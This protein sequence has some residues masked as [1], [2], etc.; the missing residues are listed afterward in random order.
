METP[1]IFIVFD[2]DQTKDRLDMAIEANAAND[3]CQLNQS[4]DKANEFVK[5]WAILHDGS[6]VSIAGA[7]IRV[8]IAPEYIEDLPKLKDIYESAV[9]SPVSIGLGLTLSEADRALKCAK[10]DG[11]DKILFYTEECD[12]QIEDAEAPEKDVVAGIAEKFGKPLVKAEHPWQNQFE[13]VIQEQIQAEA[14]KRQAQEANTEL[15]KTKMAVVSI[16]QQVRANAKELESL[17]EE[18]PHLYQ[19]IMAMTQA[20]IMIARQLKQP[21]GDLIPGGK[22]DN[23]DPATLDQEQLK[24]G[25]QEETEEHTNNPQIGQE[26]ATDHLTEDPEFYKKSEEVDTAMQKGEDLDKGINGDWSKEPG[27][28]FQINS[29]RNPD[30]HLLKVYHGRNRIGSLAYSQRPHSI[31]GSGKWHDV[32]QGQIAPEHQGKG[33]YQ[34]MLRR[35]DEHVKSLGST[36]LKSEGWQ[37]SRMSNRVWEKVGKEIN[38]DPKFGIGRGTYTFGKNDDLAKGEFRSAA[39]KHKDGT[40]AE[41]GAYH[42]IEPWLLGGSMNHRPDGPHNSSDWEAG[43]VTN[44]GA[45]MNRDQAAKHVNLQRYSPVTGQLRNLDSQ[46]PEAFGKEEEP[47]EGLRQYRGLDR[48]YFMPYQRSEPAGES[49]DLSKADGKPIQVQHYGTTPGLK[50]LDPAF[51]GTGSAGQEKNRSKRIPRTYY[52]TRPGTPESHVASGAHLYHGELPKNTKLYDMGADPLGLMAGKWKQTKNGQ[53]YEAPDKDRAE[54]KLV[55]AGYQGYHN[56][57]TKDALVYFH[58]LPVRHV[59]KSDNTGLAKAEAPKFKHFVMHYPIGFMLPTGGKKGGRIKVMHNN[60]KT[61]WISARAGL[62]QSPEGAGIP[63]SSRNPKGEGQ[64]E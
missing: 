11:G 27:Y 51:Q 35:A 23:T 28:R 18:A 44:G 15:G 26:I 54:K 20:L 25:T 38:P 17:K 19:S 29:T 59:T 49:E 64:G 1:K 5:S 4:I 22:G 37:Q 62:I 48:D 60:G 30:Y 14:A 45:F 56:Y 6:V 21:Q 32:T 52:Y 42:N 10:L 50:E 58:K 3:I 24:A 43:F 7:K 16:L 13:Q 53:M 31:Q 57:G 9:D 12:K 39:F 33:I 47:P 61:S 41:T 34:E 46:D 40:V 55:A 2:A 36:G 8:T 63:T